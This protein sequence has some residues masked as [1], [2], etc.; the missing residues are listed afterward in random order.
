MPKQFAFISRAWKKRSTVAHTQIPAF[1][2]KCRLAFLTAD[3][4]IGM[5]KGVDGQ[6]VQKGTEVVLMVTW[7]KWPTT[8]ATGNGNGKANAITI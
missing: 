3:D 2:C 6:R 5:A 1:D 7:N 4:W 8:R